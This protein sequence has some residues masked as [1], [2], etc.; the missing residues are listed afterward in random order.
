MWWPYLEL[1][2]AAEFAAYSY[3]Q[4]AQIEER[5]EGLVAAEK[6]AKSEANALRREMLT[7][8]DRERLRTR[9][10]TNRMSRLMSLTKADLKSETEER[11]RHQREYR[12]RQWKPKPRKCSWCGDEFAPKRGERGGRR[13][14]DMCSAVR[15]STSHCSEAENNESKVGEHSACGVG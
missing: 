3:C 13:Y 1:E 11:R 7:D 6:V 2:I 10:R 12:A 5:V 8:A 4:R 15:N 9:L 14:C